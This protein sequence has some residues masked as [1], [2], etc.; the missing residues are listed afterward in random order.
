MPAKAFLAETQRGTAG[1]EPAPPRRFVM[2]VPSR[3]EVRV[4]IFYMLATVF[5]F[6]V[7]NALVKWEA[8]R[9]PLG[10]VVFF[11]CALSLLPCFALVAGNGGLRLLLRTRRLKQNVLLGILQFISLMLIFAAFA[12][13]PLADV[14]AISFSTPLFL[15]LLSIPLLGERVGLHRWMAVLAGFAGV[16]LMIRAG[17]GLGGGVASTGAL[18]VLASAAIGAVVTIAVR[19]MTLTEPSPVLVTYPALV[20]AALS[21]TLLPFGW[22][23][24]DWQDAL[25]LAAIGLGSGIGQ[26]WW[27]QAFRFAPAAVA[28]PFSY[29]SMIWSMGLGY[30]FWGDVPTAM[31]IAGAAVV[32]ASGLYILYR[33]TLRR[34]PQA[35]PLAGSAD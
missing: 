4:G 13:M 21:L 23:V 3:E 29:L 6:T 11:R 9:Y 33:E 12:M 8:A 27:T 32:A 1:A 19:R 7:I 20:T 16:L 22:T 25:L 10:E 34:R 5:I 26:Y 14:V 31:L 15:T 18:L 35:A 17:G 30:L 28:A 24:P 2:P